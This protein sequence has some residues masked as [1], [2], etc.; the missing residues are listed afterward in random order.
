MKRFG[1]HR[2]GDRRGAVPRL[3]RGLVHHRRRPARRRRRRQLLS[4]RAQRRSAPREAP[5]AGGRGRRAAA[6]RSNW[7]TTATA[8]TSG[9]ARRCRHRRSG[10]SCA[11]SP[12]PAC[13]ARRADA[14]SVARLVFEPIRPQ[15]AKSP[16]RRIASVM[17]R[18]SACSWVRTRKQAPAG[19]FATS[20]STVSAEMRRMCAGHGEPSVVAVGEAFVALVEPVD[21]RRRAS[22]AASR[23]R[24]RRGRRRAAAGERAARSPASA[25]ARAASSGA[26]ASVTAPP[27]HWPSD[28]PS[29]I[30]LL[31]RARS[32]R[33]RRASPAPP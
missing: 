22:R 6:T 31:A 8:I 11:R 4:A 2:R 16:R 24:G 7:A 20:R 9:A 30:A 18:S 10:R 13:R 29:A 25:R 27:Q 3:R 12:P 14:R 21:R 19:A 32:S 23:S 26:K 1:T 15:K 28:G 5:S 33:A 17:R